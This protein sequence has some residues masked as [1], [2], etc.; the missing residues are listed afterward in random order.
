MRQIIINIHLNRC[1]DD[2]NIYYYYYYYDI[3][4]EEVHSH[5]CRYIIIVLFFSGNEY[6]TP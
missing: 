4:T 6:E 5:Q 2:N 1:E 3:D